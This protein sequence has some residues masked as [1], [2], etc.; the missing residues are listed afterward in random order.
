[1]GSLK[2]KFL[3]FSA[4]SAASPSVNMMT[5]YSVTNGKAEVFVCAVVSCRICFDEYSV[6][7]LYT[8]ENCGCRFCFSVSRIMNYALNIV[9]VTKWSVS[10][11]LSWSEF[12]DVCM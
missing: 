5:V 4:T 12:G 8:L 9:K 6:E 2:K 3:S 10:K 11:I 7:D 1:M